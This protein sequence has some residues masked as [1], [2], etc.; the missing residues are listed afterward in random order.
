MRSRWWVFLT[1]A[2]TVGAVLLAGGWQSQ[3]Q[4][5]VQV[6]V[7]ARDL[8]VPW[9]AGFA[10]DGR[11]FLTER[12]GRIRVIRNGRLDPQPWA[13]LP[14]AHVGEGGLLGLALAPD[15]ARAG[16]VYVY[17]TYEQDGRLW[18]RVL[19]IV[20]RNGR[21]RVDRTILDG[22]P[23]AGVHDGGRLRFGPDGKLYITTGDSRQPPLAQ[24]RS[25]L[26]GK[27]LRINPDGTIPT[28]NPFPNSPV[29]SLGHRN[30]Q[31]LAWH[32]D[33]KTMYAAEHG[34]SG[35]LGLC[36]HDEVNV[37]EAGKNYGWPE[38]AGL[39]GAP[40]FVDP[41]AESGANE[42]WAPSGILV[43]SSGPWRGSILVAALRGEHLRRL[44]LA[45]TEFRRVERQE[46][47]FRGELGR[48]RDI[49]QGPDGS[50][51]LLTSN[52]DGRGRPSPE[53][54]RFL[55]IVFR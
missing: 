40:R 32:P 4:T 33:T 23:G 49:V 19:R 1:L 36:C 42:T 17:H 53:D 45:A 30:P 9:A 15:F 5:S 43:P 7:V 21:G 13:T 41:I 18:N 22:I 39:G 26:A 3:G 35:E 2:A 20:E 6:E 8:E 27:I 51:Y 47:H 25:S 31:G 37:I 14:V 10:P 52:R 44:V 29:Y 50:I 46:L 12:P 38:V 55:R 11:I 48:L 28:D 24:D 16:F 54:D 34:P